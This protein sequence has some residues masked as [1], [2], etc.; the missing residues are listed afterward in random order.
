MLEF[1]RIAKKKIFIYDVKNIDFKK[2]YQ[3]IVRKRQGLSKAKFEKKYLNTPIRLY[4][5]SFFLE[6]KKLNNIVKSV[7]IYPLPKG[8]LDEKF[9]F[10]IMIKKK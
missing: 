4:E 6:D 3:E 7:K 8:A 2:K 5:K 9:G 1:V 10:C